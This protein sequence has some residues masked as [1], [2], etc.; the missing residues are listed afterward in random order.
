MIECI[1]TIDYEIYGNG[2]GSLRD[3]V[4][5]PAAR[6]IALFEQWNARFV[7]FVEVAELEKIEAL[8]TDAAIVDVRRQVLEMHERG[9]EIALHLHP[10]WFNA[11][12]Q[13]G[14]WELDYS[15][16]NLCTLPRPR[17]VQ[18]VDNSLAYLRTM[19][20][21]KTFSPLSFRAGNWLFQPTA[22]AAQVLSERGIKIDSS[23][24]KGGVQHAHRLDYRR[25]SR[26]GYYWKFRDDVNTD[27]PGGALLEIPIYTRRVPFWRM[28]TAKRVGLQ[29]KSHAAAPKVAARRKPQRLDRIRDHFRIRYPLKFDF[30]RMTLAEL[31]S[32]IDEVI[33]EDRKTPA[34]FKPLVAIGHTKD[35]ED[36][37]T[38]SAFL[39]YLKAKGIKVSTLEEVYPKCCP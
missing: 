27:D 28:L 21:E 8:A 16:Y 18:I 37:E 35:L 26:N 22:T 7:A 14:R 12:Y 13:D 11:R 20:G 30:C 33:S 29:R 3:L 34:T 32:M 2:E 24:F 6:L 39:S 15:E 25:A 23:V 17:V 19:L 5:D 38:I 1:F 9:F 10:Q 4:H 31:T 36:F